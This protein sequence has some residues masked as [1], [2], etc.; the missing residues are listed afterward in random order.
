M[1]IMSEKILVPVDGSPLSFRAL[2]HALS[3]FPDAEVAVLHVIDLFEPGYGRHLDTSFEPMLGSEEW[4]EE[5]HAATERLF[6]RVEEV[7]DEYDRTVTTE[8][9]IGDPHQVVLDYADE[10]DVDHVV[11]GAHGRDDERRPLFGQ[12]TET[13]ATRAAVPVTI[14][15]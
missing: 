8:S 1:Q 14:V 12:V 13:I 3:T 4:Y 6:E 15:R 2:R 5:A 10:E 9:E 7:A 11:L